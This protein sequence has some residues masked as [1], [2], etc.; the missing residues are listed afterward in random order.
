M[1]RTIPQGGFDDNYPLVEEIVDLPI[2][3]KR[4]LKIETEGME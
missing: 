2:F 1:K 3:L 4:N